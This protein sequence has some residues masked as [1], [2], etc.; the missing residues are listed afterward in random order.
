MAV[1][2]EKVIARF[3]NGNYKTVALTK[4]RL[5]A[6]ATK[7][8]SKLPD[9]AD[10]EAIDSALD[11]Q[12]DTYAFIEIQKNDAR[13]ANDKKK[14]EQQSQQSNNQQQ[15]QNQQEQQQ[16]SADD[17][18]AWAKALMHEVQTLKAEK[19]QATL[20]QQADT[21][22]KDVPEAYRKYA[23]ATMPKTAEEL[24]GWAEEVK[25]DYTAFRQSEINKGVGEGKVPLGASDKSAIKEAPKEQVEARA[26]RLIKI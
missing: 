7:L 3:R 23:Y 4:E 1:E 12:N 24:T 8:A 26:K 17:T 25:T 15:A 9:E 20:K 19:Q 6:I 10:D 18:P 5:D 21:L 22:L 16:Q 2:K 14:Q 11:D 13:A